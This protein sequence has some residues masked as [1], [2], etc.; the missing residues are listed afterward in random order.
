VERAVLRE[1]PSSVDP[2]E[3]ARLAADIPVPVAVTGATGFIGSHIAAAL[4][5]AGVPTRMLVRDRRRLQVD[6]GRHVSVVPGDLDD[7]PALTALLDGVGSVLHLAGRVRAG[8]V[9]A[10]E[11]ANHIGTANVVVAARKA[12]P[13]ARLVY[14][15]SLAAAGP[16]R[17]SWGVAPSDEPH[18]ISAYGRSKLGGENAVQSAAG[19]WTIVRPPAVYGPR[20]IDV[21]QFFRLAARGVVPIPAGRRWLTVVHVAD[22]VRGILRA[23]SGSVDGR[24]VHLGEPRPHELSSLVRELARAGGVHAL[25]VPIPA[26]LVRIAGQVGDGLHRLG[27]RDLALTSDKARELLARHWTART[28]ESLAALGVEGY[29]PF[30]AGARDT[31]RWYRAHGWVPRAK[32]AVA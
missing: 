23:A 6:A 11:R 15:S 5:S 19:T 25:V 24:V 31:W 3:V 18:P 22:V 4:I 20:D 21:L 17:E 14:V 1:L 30:A 16:C 26:S 9:E 7:L 27:R 12:A 8:T 13:D 29:V 32:I 28:D 10:F 2:V